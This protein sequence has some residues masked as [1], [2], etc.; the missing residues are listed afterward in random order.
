MKTKFLKTVNWMWYTHFGNL[1]LAAL[2]IFISGL[3]ATYLNFVP[4]KYIMY[5]AWLYLIV[6][7]LRMMKFTVLNLV[8]SSFEV[9]EG[10]HHFGPRWLGLYFYHRDLTF[11]VCFKE[12]CKYDLKNDDQ[13]DVNKLFGRSYGINHHDNSIRVGWRY[14]PL[15]GKIMLYSYC[16]ANGVRKISHLQNV[17]VEETFFIKIKHD[18]TPSIIISGTKNDRPGVYM[19]RWMPWKLKKF[20]YK[21]FPY[22]GGNSTAPHNMSV[23][24]KEMFQA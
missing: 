11:E 10:K 18:L 20:G 6:F 17:E 22:F 19:L 14:N 4:G 5:A 3:S 24:L 1:A 7:F 12:S 21:L 13:L 23:Y 8:P 15:I 16:Y 9:E 2:I